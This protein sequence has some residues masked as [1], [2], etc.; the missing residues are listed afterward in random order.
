[1]SLHRG[2]HSEHCLGIGG[3]PGH[4]KC[5]CFC[6]HNRPE[7]VQRSQVLAAWN[8]E[9]ERLARWVHDAEHRTFGAWDDDIMHRSH[10]M[11]AARTF[12]GD[13]FA[14]T[15]SPSPVTDGLRERVIAA[16][17]SEDE[18]AHAEAWNE[19]ENR[20]I[21]ICAYCGHEW[22]CRTQ[23]AIDRLLAALRATPSPVPLD[24]KAEIIR[25]AEEVTGDPALLHDVFALRP[26]LRRRFEFVVRKWLAADGAPE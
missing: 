13:P 4:D 9:A 17:T 2:T 25:L 7:D 24:R 21:G 10:D 23:Q 11:D 14:A 3:G 22:P 8:R 18:I 26:D 12:L 20:G 19:A 6:H 16:L 15:P 1:M 5:V